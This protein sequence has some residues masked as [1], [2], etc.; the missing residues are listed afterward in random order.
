[1]KSLFLLLFYLFSTT[2]FGQIVVDKAGDGWDLR[3]DSALNLIKINDPSKYTLL[4]NYCNKIEFWNGCYSTNDGIKSIIIS[5]GDIKLGSV[6]NLAAVVIH[7]S[8]HLYY[9]N[10]LHTLDVQ[11]EENMCYRY[12]FSFLEKLPDVEGW[13]W[14]HTLNQIIT[15]E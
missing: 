10:T 2:C 7:E 4:K 5:T 13:L 1:M 9:S 6:N 14:T 12:E 15:T 3:V 8:L 11:E